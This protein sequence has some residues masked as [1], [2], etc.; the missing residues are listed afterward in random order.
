MIAMWFIGI[1]SA[2]FVLDYFSS[3]YL[4]GRI[5]FE[6]LFLQVGEKVHTYC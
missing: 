4:H 3:Y 6:L 2:F 1:G 5:R